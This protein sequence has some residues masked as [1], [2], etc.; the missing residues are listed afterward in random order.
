MSKV[1]EFIKYVRKHNFGEIKE[2]VSFKKLTSLK[3]GGICEALYIPSDIESLTISLRYLKENKIKYYVI[4]HGT[5]MLVNDHYFEMVLI[6]LKKFTDYYLL[7]ETISDY[8]FYVETGVSAC[9]L[10]RYLVNQNI[11]GGEFI[12][13]IPGSIGG[14]TYMNAGAYKKSMSDIIYSITYF[15]EQGLLQT[16]LNKNN[17]F[18]FSYRNSKFKETN[19][20]ILSI[21]IKL[22]KKERAELPIIKLNRYLKQKQLDQPLNSYNAGSTFK[23]NN[24]HFFAWQIID[25]LGYR[26]KMIGDALVSTKHANFLINNGNARFIDMIML[27]QMIR[28]DA[29]NK[30]GID[31]ECEWEILQ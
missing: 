20:V 1:Q 21:V 4:G 26:G 5:N 6:S 16:E 29:K 28:Y 24:E 22:S 15:D 30:L 10:S 13:V 27:I 17:C 11:S 7:E 12:G 3:I 14:L 9:T 31:L 18:N 19:F 8:Y 25:K 2:E 23:N